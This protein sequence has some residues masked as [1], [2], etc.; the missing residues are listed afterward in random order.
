MQRKITSFVILAC[1]ICLP[2]SAN[3]GCPSADNRI[4]VS[5]PP[6]IEAVKLSDL[7]F[8]AWK[9]LDASFLL[10]NQASKEIVY[11]TIVLEYQTK[12]ADYSQSVVYEAA[13]QTKQPSDYLIPAERVEPL[14]HPIFPGQE[15]WISG[16]S[17]YTPPECPV[18]ARVIMLDIHFGDGSS[19]RWESSDW[20]TE[21]LLADYS[22]YLSIPDSKAWTSDKYFFL[23]KI[24]R[25]GQLED[26][27][28]F[29]KVPS[30]TVAEALKKLTFSP[31]LVKGKPQVTAIVLIIRFN[32]QKAAETVPEQDAQEPIITKPAV[33]ISLTPRDSNET[34]W[35]F[36]FG[37]GFGY[38]TSVIHREH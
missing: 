12:N 20:W 37:S 22:T 2:A 7:G 11:L 18:S 29:T 25:E 35:G 10:K 33:F 1:F 38:T 5:V 17:P 16:S 13:P 3:I 19:L 30:A 26:I 8:A 34:D 36:V 4:P 31:S 21:P 32:R 14:P 15:K 28:P 9:S 6:E 23:G 24:N 27:E